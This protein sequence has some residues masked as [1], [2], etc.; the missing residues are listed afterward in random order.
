MSIAG[1]DARL[2]FIYIRLAWPFGVDYILLRGSRMADGGS[3]EEK[4]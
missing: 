4:I 3:V 1:T 2:R